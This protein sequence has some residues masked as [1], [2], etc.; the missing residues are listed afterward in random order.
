MNHATGSSHQRPDSEHPTTIEAVPPRRMFLFEPGWRVGVK[1]GS[2]REF[3]YMMAPG[4]DFY[5]RLLDGEV[6]LFRER[7]KALPGL[8]R[9]TRPR[10]FE[11]KQLREAIV[12]VP[13]DLEAIP[14]ELDVSSIKRERLDRPTPTGKIELGYRA[15]F[16]SLPQEYRA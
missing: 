2:H 11:P 3:C 6:F 7:G 16:R 5:H 12:P 14:L 1:T 8:R 4:Q 9:A 15:R 13:A 10:Q